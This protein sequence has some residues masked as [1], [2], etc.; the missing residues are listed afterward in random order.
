M[1]KIFEDGS[2]I[3]EGIVSVMGGNVSD[4][5]NE[6]VR[7]DANSNYHLIRIKR[8]SDGLGIFVVTYNDKTAVAGDSIWTG[9]DKELGL[10]MRNLID[11]VMPYEMR[12]DMVNPKQISITLNNKSITS[13]KL[14]RTLATRLIKK[15]EPFMPHVKALRDQYE[16]SDK[17][18]SEAVNELKSIGYRNASSGDK[19]YAH[20]RPTI[21]VCAGGKVRLDYSPT[22]TVDQMKRILAILSEQ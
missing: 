17:K 13:Y 2:A 10:N 3:I 14:G 16:N 20:N 18:R 19:M 8:S 9:R 7:S 1:S 21:D 15:I 12:A 22:V 11:T 6:E 5:A 4:W